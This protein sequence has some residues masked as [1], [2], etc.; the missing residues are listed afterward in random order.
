MLS[1]HNNY[2]NGA[3]EQDTESPDIQKPTIDD[4]TVVVLAAA[5][6]VTAGSMTAK[7]DI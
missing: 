7:E 5:V 3:L 4:C 2:C 6:C 1:T